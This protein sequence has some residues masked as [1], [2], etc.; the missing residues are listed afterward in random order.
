MG[1]PLWLLFI[2]DSVRCQCC[3]CRLTDFRI[4]TCWGGVVIYCVLTS[5][6]IIKSNMDSGGYC[7][8][9]DLITLELSYT[10]F[11]PYSKGSWRSSELASFGAMLSTLVRDEYS[12]R[13]KADMLDWANLL[14]NLVVWYYPSLGV[15]VNLFQDSYGIGI[16]DETFGFWL[17]SE[18][19]LPLGSLLDYNNWPPIGLQLIVNIQPVSKVS[20]PDLVVSP[21]WATLVVH[22]SEYCPKSPPPPYGTCLTY[23]LQAM[24]DV[25]VYG[26]RPTLPTWRG[27]IWHCFKAK[28]DNKV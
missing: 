4:Y 2:S 8:L 26:A 22:P 13:L 15:W 10:C 24:L 12:Y 28:K 1:A 7:Q 27:L 25:I 6:D 9:M 14:G 17:G 11:I 3:F 20:Y 21:L 16:V 18:L 5:V 19:G 23:P